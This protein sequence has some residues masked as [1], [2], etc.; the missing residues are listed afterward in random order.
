ML[1]P[2]THFN[3][4]IAN[5]YQ[6]VNHIQGKLIFN[7]EEYVK[8]QV[9]YNITVDLYERDFKLYVRVL[10]S[11]REGK[12]NSEVM[13]VLGYFYRDISFIVLR[14]LNKYKDCFFD[15]DI[16]VKLEGLPSYTIY[17][18]D[19]RE[20]IDSIIHMRKPDTE[21]TPVDGIEFFKL[22]EPAYR[23]EIPIKDVVCKAATLYYFSKNAVNIKWR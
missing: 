4:F 5:S 14:S 3:F 2:Y 13:K 22:V 11:I 7:F 12:I 20:N 9:H 10:K 17:L 6:Y 19:V 21:L 8:S 15:F 1:I 16:V 18:E 23:T